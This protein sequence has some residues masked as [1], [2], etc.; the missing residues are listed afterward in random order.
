MLRKKGSFISSSNRCYE[1]HLFFSLRAT[2]AT[3]I[4]FLLLFEQMSLRKPT[5][6]FS[7]SNRTKI[8]RTGRITPRQPW[9][10]RAVCCSKNQEVV[11]ESAALL[12]EIKRFFIIRVLPVHEIK[13]PNNFRI[14]HIHEI[15]PPPIFRI[16]SI[17]EIELT[18][19]FQVLFRVRNP[20]S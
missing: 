8:K 2:A 3:K 1:S 6:C 16:L 5:I 10:C 15:K 14:S 4:F 12:H 19:V 13:L 17:H 9:T 20:L 11:R 18:P 7:S